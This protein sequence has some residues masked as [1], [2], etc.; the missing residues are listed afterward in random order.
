MLVGPDDLP[1]YKNIC[2]SL[3]RENELPNFP[4]DVSMLKPLRSRIKIARLLDI[5]SHR[6][7][8]NSHSHNWLEKTAAAMDIDLDEDLLMETQIAK[9]K[10]KGNQVKVKS[11]RAE[12]DKLLSH[13]VVPT[14]LS[15]LTT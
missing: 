4:V 13:K 2:K 1:S 11:L 15:A 3:N 12:L 5:E 10:S 8:K 6:S 9:E 14:H 7:R